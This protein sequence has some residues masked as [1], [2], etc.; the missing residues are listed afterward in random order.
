MVGPV[1]VFLS[2][3]V[4]ICGHTRCHTR[5]AHFAICVHWDWFPAVKLNSVV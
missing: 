3:D 1:V 5:E 2:T 4:G